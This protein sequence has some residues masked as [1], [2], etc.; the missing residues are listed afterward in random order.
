MIIDARVFTGMEAR[1]SGIWGLLGGPDPD[2]CGVW[3][4]L[5]D[6]RAFYARVLAVLLSTGA[7]LPRFSDLPG[8]SLASVYYDV[9]FLGRLQ[10]TDKENALGHPG[11]ND[12]SS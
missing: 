1:G 5:D 10:S 7:S 8:S 12:T 2:G 11:A 4:Y 3:P 6:R 9:E